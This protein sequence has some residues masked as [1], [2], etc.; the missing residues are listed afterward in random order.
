MAPSVP[1]VET[2]MPGLKEWLSAGALLLAGNAVMAQQQP[3]HVFRLTKSPSNVGVCNALDAPMSREHTVTVMGNKA[4]LK[5]PGGN[6]E[7][8]KQVGAG[9]YRTELELG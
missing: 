6:D 9:T 7:D 1:L 8:M 5:F 2:T 4:V 3:S